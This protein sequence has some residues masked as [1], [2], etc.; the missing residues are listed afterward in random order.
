MNRRHLKNPYWYALLVPLVLFLGLVALGVSADTISVPGRVLIFGMLAYVTA[1]YAGRAPRLI[2]EANTL[3]ESRHIVGLGMFLVAQMMSQAYGVVYVSLDRP[4]WIASQYYVPAF[5]TLGS[6]G[7]AFVASS[8]PRFPF[9]PFGRP[10][11]LSSWASIL[12]ALVSSGGLYL[13]SHA[14]YVVKFISGLWGG[15]MRAF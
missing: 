12:F 10:K 4:E 8:I 14:P 15:I 5:I 13:V 6:V 2:W 3:P 11:G 9:P 1:R 7:L